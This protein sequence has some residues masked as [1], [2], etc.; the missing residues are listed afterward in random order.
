MSD[1]PSVDLPAWIEQFREYLRVV[2]RPMTTVRAYTVALRRF[3]AFAVDRRLTVDTAIAFAQDLSVA[4]SAKSNYLAAV[5][6]FYR[7]L[8]GR[9]L[10][11]IPNRDWEVFREFRHEL[12]KFGE[13]VPHPPSEEAIQTLLMRAHDHQPKRFQSIDTQF[14]RELAHRR[15]LAMLEAL[16]S[17]GMRVSELV[18]LNRDNLNPQDHSARVIGKGRKERVV[19]FDERAWQAIEEYL[20][21]RA[22]QGSPYGVAVFARHNVK[23]KHVA[24]LSTRSVE[25]LFDRLIPDLK[26]QM[27][28]TPHSLRHAFATRALEV[29]GNLAIV[30]D[31]MGHKSPLTTRIYA[32]V[33]NKQLYEAH[34]KIFGG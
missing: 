19:Y 2:N 17:S 12:G 28:F 10:V 13:R 15:N 22:D 33:S 29:T 11:E 3:Q 25:R 16:R 26:V 4:P 9:G 30:Q 6:K 24:R 7:F 27:R 5:S 23:F 32:K 18:S 34:R 31:L 21:L 8:I 1:T 14:R 20:Q